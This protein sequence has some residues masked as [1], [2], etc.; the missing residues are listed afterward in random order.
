MLGQLFWNFARGEEGPT[1]VEYAA[2]LALIV[3]VCIGAVATVGKNANKHSR[4]LASR[5]MWVVAKARR[6]SWLHQRTETV[7]IWA[8]KYSFNPSGGPT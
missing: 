8:H 3:A 7:K 6:A 1:A 5:S 2:L 4:R